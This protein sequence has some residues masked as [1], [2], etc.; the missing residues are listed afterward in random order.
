MNRLTLSNRRQHDVADLIFRGRRYVVGSSRFADGG[1]AEIF[2]DTAKAASE[3]ADD[4]RDIAI[5]LSLALQHSVPVKTIR[6][7]VGDGL[8]AAA[9]D[10]LEDKTP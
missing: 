1:L 9:I 2:I 5:L 8:A 3:A 10:T 7:A 4:A 6:H